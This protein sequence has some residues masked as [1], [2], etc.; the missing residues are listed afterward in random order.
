MLSDGI[1]LFPTFMHVTNTNMDYTVV[2]IGDLAS[3]VTVFGFCTRTGHEGPSPFQP[4]ED[5][6][7]KDAL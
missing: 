4:P 3:F 1:Y 7:A 5:V 6:N 2:I